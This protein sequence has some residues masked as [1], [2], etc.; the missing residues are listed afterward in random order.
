MIESEQKF[1]EEMDSLKQIREGTKL[2]LDDEKKKIEEIV[3]AIN[4]S[5]NEKMMAEMGKIIDGV[6]KD[7]WFVWL[8]R[9]ILL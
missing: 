4:A 2:G 6:K 3:R 8:S 1:K 5:G 7:E 9:R